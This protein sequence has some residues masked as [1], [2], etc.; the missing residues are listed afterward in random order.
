MTSGAAIRRARPADLDRIEALERECFGTVDGAF[1]RRQLRRLLANP[2]ARWM[3][4]ADGQAVACWLTAGNG[5]ARWLRLYSLA[6]HPG[7][8]GQG[9]G[10]RLLSSGLA[11]GRT[12]GFSACRAEVRASNHGARR[13]Y[14]QFGFREAGRL[15]DYYGRGI[16]GVRLALDLRRARPA[17]GPRAETNSRVRR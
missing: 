2:R 5:R 6:V 12:Q 1:S 4:A 14:E 11:W 15:P 10:K 16:D 17:A 7:L 13:L 9:W 3:L 8:R